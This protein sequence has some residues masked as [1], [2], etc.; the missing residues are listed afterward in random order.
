MD[1]PLDNKESTLGGFIGPESAFDKMT[2]QKITT[3]L[4]VKGVPTTVSGRI[5][6]MLP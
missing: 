5:L 2:F 3:V 4:S 6:N 1:K